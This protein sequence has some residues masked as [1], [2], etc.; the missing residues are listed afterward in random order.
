MREHE[1][2][3]IDKFNG[4][5][6]RADIEDTPLDHFS[7]CNNVQY[8]GSTSFGTR[9]GIGL[10]QQLAGPLS[11]ILRF[12]NYPTADKS[13]LLILT[14]GG[15][16]YHVIDSVTIFGP[17]L[18]IPTMT[19]F[20]FVPYAGRAYIT[21]FTTQLVAG[22]NRELGLSG[23]YVY[24][25]KGDGTPARR[26]GGNPPVAT[27]VPANGAAGFNDAGVHI[28]GYVYETDTG[29]LTAPG[30]LAAFTTTAGVS[31][32]FTNIGNSPDGFVAKKHLVA[33]KV[34]QNYNGDVNGYQLFFIPGAD[35]PNNITT[36]L[37]NISFF[38]ADLLEDASHL[39]DNFSLI[40]AGV[41][42]F[43]Y[44]NRLCVVGEHD[45]SS[46]VRVSSPGEPEAINQI[47]GLCQVPPKGNPL[48]NGSEMR[49]VMYVF[50]RN[51][52]IS[53]VDNNNDPT[54]WPMS[55]VDNAMGTGVHGIATV[56]DS[57]SASTDYLMVSAYRGI[58]LFNGTYILPE[59]TW[60]IQNFWIQQTFKTDF[61]RIQIVNDSLGQ[62]LYIVL[63]DRR[64]L[65]GNYVNGLDPKSIRWAPWSF[66]LFVNTIALVNIN[67]VVFGCDQI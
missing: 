67:D 39:S 37:N 44:H 46:T 20:G 6:D 29:Y 18:I 55:I 36:V 54:S 30:G 38:D 48:T 34:I 28:F 22:M 64:V 7:E 23:E 3:T 60:K 57:G 43:T 13:T 61:R 40:P 35:I 33:S 5:W 52:T 32:S 27:I 4:L 19:D 2:I 45:N 59:L 42:L 31:V 25:Y 49:D 51:R 8:P 10:Y 17:I 9:D 15:M 14:T 12:Y 16:I 21:P 41:N 66:D 62:K 50:E 65:H 53:F 56:L 63:T 11:S 1:P 24:V 58:C 26:A 47:T